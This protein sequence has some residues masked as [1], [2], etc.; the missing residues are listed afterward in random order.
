MACGL[1]RIAPFV[2]AATLT[3]LAATPGASAAQGVSGDEFGPGSAGSG[4][5]YFPLA[6]N[7]GYDVEHYLV[8]L[9]YDP[10]AQHL[11]ATARITA[12]AT[13][14]LSRFNL[15]YRGPDIE[16][17]RVD[18]R[19][20]DFRRDGKELVVSPPRGLRERRKFDVEVRYAGTP[21]AIEGPFGLRFGW[22]KTD[23]GTF[24]A[25]QP[26]AASTWYPVNEHPTDKATYT[27]HATVPEGTTAVA[28]GRLL[29]RQERDGWTTFRWR[30]DEPIA[31]YLT[32]MTIGRFEVQ[33]GRTDSGIRN[34]TAVDPDV[35]DVPEAAA[36]FE[37]TNRITDYFGTV[38]TPY[39]F[40]VTGGVVDDAEDLGY[41]METQTKSVYSVP[42]SEST[43]AHEVGHHWFGDAVSPGRWQ[44]IW[45]NE[46]LATWASWLWSEHTGGPTAAEL[47]RQNYEEVAA[48]DEF[49]DVSI[50]DPGV[51]R[52]FSA[53]VYD[54]GAM[55]VQ[56][57]RD[58]VGDEAF[59]EILRTWVTE[60]RHGTAT[61]PDFVALAERISGAELDRFFD[62][63]LFTPEKPTT[64]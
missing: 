17:V 9:T 49:W 13:R 63:W 14:N 5:P 30:A 61:T 15:D 44:D 18:G 4:D 12:T 34:F 32:T 58:K 16:D 62:V 8:D 21:R 1:S 64:W 33:R 31:S 45:L 43:V 59:F 57:L 42:R 41:A 52:M 20:A 36:T 29:A 40:A 3:A 7:G 25:N 38:F 24:V 11:D 2:A 47:F 37:L 10:R 51:D 53:P 48:G 19:A 27:F 56:A 6:G 22:Y 60:H 23:D 54:R 35:A 46:G 26:V 50:G 55:A 28:N 39:P